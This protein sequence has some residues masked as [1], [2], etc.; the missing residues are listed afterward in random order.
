MAILHTYLHED[1]ENESNTMIYVEEKVQLV[2]K[3]KE[4]S[5]PNF[6]VVGYVLDFGG[7]QTREGVTP[8]TEHED[9]LWAL[10]E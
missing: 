9:L 8:S 2:Y 1:V 3:G 5:H 6:C 4:L 7:H 10:Q